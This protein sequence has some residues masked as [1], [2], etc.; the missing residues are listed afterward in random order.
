MKATASQIYDWIINDE[1]ILTKEGRITFSLGSINIQVKQKD[2]VGNL[3]QEWVEGWMKSREI[4][5]QPNPNS[6]MPP[7]FFLL[8]DNHEK[9]LLEIKAFNA[10]GS[11][12]FD[13]A[14]FRAYEEELIEKPYMLDVDYLIF[15]YKMDEN[16]IVTVKDVWLKKVWEITRSMDNWPLNLQVKAGVVHKI[17]PGVWYRKTQF[18]MFQS[19]EHFLSALEQTVWQNPKTREESS[20]WMGKFQKAYSDYYHT[21]LAIP[22]W[23]DI[24]DL[25][26]KKSKSK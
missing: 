4:E 19:K 13:I 24:K 9:N 6:Q 5:F 21:E 14:D 15:G 3:L 18:D 12:G 7:D 8:P 22:R 1:Q 2:V 25:Y 10:S 26:K 17:R 20:T 11:P 23:N 16:G